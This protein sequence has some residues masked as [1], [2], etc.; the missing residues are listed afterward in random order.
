M[1]AHATV[2]FCRDVLVES[3]GRPEDSLSR[4]Q[5]SV[6]R[7]VLLY[8]PLVLK[9][10]AVFPTT[11]AEEF[12]HIMRALTEQEAMEELI[13]S[14]L[15][16]PLLCST[17]EYHL[18]LP[19][20]PDAL[21][22]FKRM[23]WSRGEIYI[24]YK[25]MLRNRAWFVNQD[26]YELRP[27]RRVMKY[28]RVWTRRSMTTR[29]TQS[30]LVVPMLLDVL[31]DFILQHGSSR[32]CMVALHVIIDRFDDVLLSASTQQRVRML[33]ADSVQRIVH[34]HPDLLKASC[35]KVI[36]TMRSHFG[37]F[38][39]SELLTSLF[40]CIG[41]HLEAANP[42]EIR[43]QRDLAA[44][45]KRL[46]SFDPLM[47]VKTS[48]LEVK[49]S[50]VV[51]E[52]DS[53]DS[54]DEDA[55]ERLNRE[56]RRLELM[57]KYE[58]TMEAIVFHLLRR[59][60]V[61]QTRLDHLQQFA[62]APPDIVLKSMHDD[63]HDDEDDH[64]YYNDDGDGYDRYR[65][66]S[67][68]GGSGGAGGSSYD[69][70]NDEDSSSDSSDGDE[71]NTGGF[72]RGDYK[73]FEYWD[74]A[75]Q[76]GG[77]AVGG[78]GGAGGAGGNRRDHGHGG[79]GGRTGNSGA[80]RKGKRRVDEDDVDQ[81]LD[82]L[83][84]DG[85]DAVDALDDACTMDA[86]YEE[87]MF[88][89]GGGL[90]RDVPDDLGSENPRDYQDVRVDGV[91]ERS[92]RSTMRVAARMA[93]NGAA[94]SNYLLSSAELKLRAGLDDDDDDEAFD[95]D[96]TALSSSAASSM[97]AG[98]SS[99]SGG[100]SAASGS[101]ATGGSGSAASAAA[102]QAAQ[103]E[104]DGRRGGVRGDLDHISKYVWSMPASSS[105]SDAGADGAMSYISVLSCE[106]LDPAVLLAESGDPHTRLAY[107]YS[108]P[109][110]AVPTTALPSSM[111][112]WQAQQSVL[113][114]RVVRTKR[115]ILAIIV[116]LAKIACRYVDFSARVKTVF[117]RISSVTRDQEVLERVEH[118]VQLLSKAS[119]AHSVFVSPFVMTTQS[120]FSIDDYTPLSVLT[121]AYTI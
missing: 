54:D 9:V 74:G 26:E 97:A 18:S 34:R 93:A 80:E 59:L 108:E 110:P 85:L 66:R 10:L 113:D 31:I 116:A 19:S 84:V 100:A 120:D 55:R 41:E 52:D 82:L 89:G 25:Y 21:Q 28:H 5:V 43:R 53:D 44:Q 27:A 83:G 79:R 13:H 99:G 6:R 36:S 111:P 42:L 121:N 3:V 48:T 40:F 114:A 92:W 72:G 76:Y 86:A 50:M 17:I 69:Y 98:A 81:L 47:D 102:A 7:V 39:M 45:K 64:D 23:L 65:V 24:P 63:D 90:D 61:L 105:S 20:N 14:V 88:M 46:K 78:A 49:R 68:G 67:R 94:R 58:S 56:L 101:S 62:M 12:C 57:A 60:H 75:D 33:L 15:D 38:E 96:G 87:V 112:W 4:G 16:L 103:A 29:V 109:E 71:D 115:M 77:R 91:S 32:L 30:C 11:Y 51:M 104:D 106:S 2:Q 117:T 73:D 1:V 70:K 95:D 107:S 35:G 118:G 8:F 37:N 119:M 22:A